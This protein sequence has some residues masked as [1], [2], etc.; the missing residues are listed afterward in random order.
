M[1]VQA[2]LLTEENMGA[3]VKTPSRGC[4]FSGE[5]SGLLGT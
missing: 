5:V 2:P 3:C 4:L 1:S